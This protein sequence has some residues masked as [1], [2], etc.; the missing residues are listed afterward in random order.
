MD[1]A[2]KDKMVLLNK[3]EMVK[4]GVIQLK[5]KKSGKNNFQKYDYYQLGDFLPT[6]RSLLKKYGLASE[7]TFS[8]HKGTLTI[9]DCETGMYRKWKID[10]PDMKSTQPT[11]DMQTIGAL[12]TYARRYLYLQA[13]EI[14]EGDP[15]DAGDFEEPKPV[16]PKKQTK[17]TVKQV[18]KP[19][20]KEPEYNTV[21]EVA[22]YLKEFYT[23]HKIELTLK[24]GENTINKLF[25]DGKITEELR[26]KSIKEIEETFEGE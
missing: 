7:V 26:N 21:E 10:L 17:K 8:K 6:V 20:P 13:L 23:Q 22:K 16:K 9:F 19:E 11:K 24:R 1:C 5:P 2:T 25:K 4:D 18:K 14:A 3:I 12:Q 15:I